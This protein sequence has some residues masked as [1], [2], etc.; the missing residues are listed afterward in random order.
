MGAKRLIM[1]AVTVVLVLCRRGNTENYD[2]SP[3]R[4]NDQGDCG[5]GN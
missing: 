5:G 3:G 2:N 4:W 1:F